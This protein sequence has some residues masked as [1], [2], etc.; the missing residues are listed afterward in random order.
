MN[1]SDLLTPQLIKI[2]LESEDKEELF[3]EMVQLFVDEDLL[4]DRDAALEA[5]FEREAKMSTGISK[6]L[7]L[8]HGKLDEADGLLISVATSD[9]GIEYDSLDGELV[10]V[11]VMVFAEIGNPGP[12]IEALA[13]ISRLFSIPG[14][15]D[16]V[17]AARLPED[18]L[19][20]IKEEE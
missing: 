20:M 17:R 11:V 9:I 13:E 12:H 16:R 1:I 7:A 18:I 15:I 19:S 4:S 10:Y 8:P 14:F 5:L 6:W 2:D 3:E